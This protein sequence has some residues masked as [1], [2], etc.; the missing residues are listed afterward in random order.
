MGFDTHRG[1]S[2]VGFIH[3]SDV[4]MGAMASQ[5]LFMF[6]K[7]L[8]EFESESEIT[9]VSSVYSIVS[10]GADQRQHQSSASLAFVRGIH[11]WSVSSPHI[12]PATRKMFPLDEVIMTIQNKSRWMMLGMSACKWVV[13]CMYGTYGR[14]VHYKFPIQIYLQ[15]SFK[16]HVWMSYWE[17]DLTWLLFI[18]KIMLRGISSDTS[19]YRPYANHCPTPL[20][21][22]IFFLSWM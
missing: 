4:M 19:A 3:Y 21:F 20:L 5:F 9:D 18:L 6:N 16:L 17:A 8:S 15:T 7:I 22:N 12:G 1:I 2:S 14:I 13:G 11:R 10:A